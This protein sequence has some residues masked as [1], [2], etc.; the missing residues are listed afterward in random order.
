MLVY[1]YIFFV[2]I[3][4]ESFRLRYM[5]VCVRWCCNKMYFLLKVIGEEFGDFVKVVFSKF[6]V[7]FVF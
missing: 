6:W 7:G 1:V 2:N 5:F 3:V 4:F